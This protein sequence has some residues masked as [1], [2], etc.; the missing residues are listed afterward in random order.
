MF[1]FVTLRF[2]SNLCVTLIASLFYFLHV[3]IVCFIVSCI[4][5]L[6]KAFNHCF[7]KRQCLTVCT[8]LVH[9]FSYKTRWN[10]LCPLLNRKIPVRSHDIDLSNAAIF[11]PPCLL[12][13]IYQE[14]SKLKFLE[15]LIIDYSKV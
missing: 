13:C 11:M 7:N 4:T 15:F 5:E 2:L 10:S 14:R 9:Y 6:I 12:E 1:L 8:N 3:S